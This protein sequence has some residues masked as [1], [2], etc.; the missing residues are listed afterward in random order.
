MSPEEI[1]KLLKKNKWTHA[2]LAEKLGVTT[3]YIALLVM[4]R[5]NPSKPLQKLFESIKK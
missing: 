3:Q 4:G 1:K 2:R 5:R